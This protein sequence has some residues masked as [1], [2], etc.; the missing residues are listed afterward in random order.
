MEVIGLGRRRMLKEAERRFRELI[1]AVERDGPQ[2]VTRR[3]IDVAVVMGIDD[4]RNSVGGHDLKS[5]LLS[6]PSLDQLE[7]DRDGQFIPV[8]DL[9]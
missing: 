8:V 7:I 9:E 6:G 2:V 4:Y 3:G 1:R 5:V